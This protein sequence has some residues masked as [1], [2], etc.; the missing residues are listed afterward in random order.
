M[1]NCFVQC[2]FPV[3]HVGSNDSAVKLTQDE[4]D[5]W[6]SLQTL[7]VQCEGNPMSASALEVCGVQSVDQVLDQQLTRLEGEKV[8]EHK[9]TFLD[10]LKGLEVARQYLCQFDTK[11]NIVVICRKVESELFRLRAKEK[12]KQKADWLKKYCN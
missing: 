7:G 1:K 8:A 11:K 2:G 6:N 3:D 4:E 12:Q 10:A 5:D 9:A